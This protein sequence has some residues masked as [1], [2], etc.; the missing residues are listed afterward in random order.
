M[1]V[2][3]FLRCRMNCFPANNLAAMMVVLYLSVQREING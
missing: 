2:V 3:C 1:M